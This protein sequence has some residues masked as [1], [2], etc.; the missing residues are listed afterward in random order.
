ME[1]IK[2][3]AQKGATVNNEDRLAL[4]TLLIKHGYSVRIGKEKAEGK[5]TSTIFVGYEEVAR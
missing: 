3:S 5:Q 2:I 1:E 4:A